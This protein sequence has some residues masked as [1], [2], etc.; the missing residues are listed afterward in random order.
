M[1]ARFDLNPVSTM[2]DRLTIYSKVVRQIKVATVME[3][4]TTVERLDSPELATRFWHETVE[5]SPWFDSMK[6]HM[7]VIL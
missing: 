5:L 1:K 2:Q 6:E 4:A 3:Q 7:A